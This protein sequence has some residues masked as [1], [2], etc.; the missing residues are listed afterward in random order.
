MRPTTWLRAASILTLVHAILHTI[1]GV[2]GDPPAGPGATAYAV[3][4]ASTFLVMGNTRSY[5]AFYRGMGLSVTIFLVVEA[6]IFWL[7]GNIVRDSD[8]DLRDL[9]VVFLLGY[10]ALAVNSIRYFFVAPV[11]VELTIAGC[12]AMAIVSIKQ[13]ARRLRKVPSSYHGT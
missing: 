9:L 6:L 4:K 3:M 10:L 12:L 7:L 13:P 5:W 2:F 8:T 11:I 1:G